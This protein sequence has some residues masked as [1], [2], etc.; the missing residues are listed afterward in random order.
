MVDYDDMVIEQV[1]VT[2]APIDGTGAVFAV[3]LKTLEFVSSELVDAPQPSEIS[4]SVTNASGSKNGKDDD[5]KR[6][7][8]NQTILAGIADSVGKALGF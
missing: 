3:S 6:A 8:K 2:R 5:A 7:A 1:T 4:G